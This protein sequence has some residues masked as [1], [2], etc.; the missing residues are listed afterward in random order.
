MNSLVIEFMQAR[1]TPPIA[2]LR[3]GM[4]SRTVPIR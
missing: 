3:R 4:S 1:I 2:S